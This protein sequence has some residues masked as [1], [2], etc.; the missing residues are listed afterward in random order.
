MQ[1]TLY[2]NQRSCKLR[3]KIRDMIIESEVNPPSMP[4]DI[5]FSKK[6]GRKQDGI[7]LSPSHKM[8]VKDMTEE[9]AIEYAELMRVTFI[10]HWK[11][12]QK[13]KR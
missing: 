5:Y 1:V 12:K 7:F 3:L 6:P 4:N 13:Q 9:Q 11:G 8:A 10:E 2:N